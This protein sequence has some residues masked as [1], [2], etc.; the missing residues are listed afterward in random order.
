MTKHTHLCEYCGRERPCLCHDVADLRF[1][2]CD[3]CL[4]DAVIPPWKPKPQGM[5]GKP[6]SQHMPGTQ[7]ALRDREAKGVDLL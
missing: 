2:P 7:R 4:R 5:K 3:R 6:L 1:L